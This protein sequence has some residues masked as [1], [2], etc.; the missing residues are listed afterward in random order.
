MD[1][2]SRIIIAEYCR[3]HRSKK[4]SQLYELL[5][6]SYYMDDEPTEEDSIFLEKIIKNEKDP[7]LKEALKDLED[8]LLF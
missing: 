6:F 2:Y 1:E 8:F 7:I 3:S 5:E 4:S